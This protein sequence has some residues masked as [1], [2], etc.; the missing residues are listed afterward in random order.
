MSLV[1]NMDILILIVTTSGYD[2][3]LHSTTFYFKVGQTVISMWDRDS[4]LQVGQCLF[5]TRAKVFPKWG[6]LLQSGAKYYFRV[7]QLFQSEAIISRWDITPPSNH[8]A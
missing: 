8:L 1:N 2:Q 7:G 4:Y 3:L 5:Q 6:Q